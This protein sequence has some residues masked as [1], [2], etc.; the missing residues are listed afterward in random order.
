MPRVG[1]LSGKKVEQET[2]VKQIDFE[3]SFALLIYFPLLHCSIFRQAK[4]MESR[5]GEQ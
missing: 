5:A 3:H 1:G 2:A 4:K